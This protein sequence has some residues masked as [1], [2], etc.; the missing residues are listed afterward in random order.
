MTTVVILENPTPSFISLTI[1]SSVVELERSDADS[2]SLSLI[3]AIEQGPAGPVGP[4]GPIGPGHYDDMP[5]LYLF[6]EGALI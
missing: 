6:F 3:T 1:D 5:D 2:N 4:T